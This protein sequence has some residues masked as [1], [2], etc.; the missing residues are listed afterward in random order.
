MSNRLIYIWNTLPS[1]IFGNRHPPSTTSN[2]ASL[3]ARRRLQTTRI[4]VKTPQDVAETI[5][6]G[7]VFSNA[8]KESPKIDGRIV[9]LQLLSKLDTRSLQVNSSDTC[10]GQDKENIVKKYLGKTHAVRRLPVL[11]TTTV[12][13]DVVI[14]APTVHV[15]VFLARAPLVN[16]ETTLTPRRR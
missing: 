11:W 6:R 1:Y 7:S 9:F 13:W 5:K 12:Q 14:V 15:S 2:A 16:E 10:G 3:R 4:D 8:K